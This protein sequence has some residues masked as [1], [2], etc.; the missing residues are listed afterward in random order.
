M[1]EENPSVLSD[2][3][4]IQEVLDSYRE[5]VW[6]FAPHHLKPFQDRLRA[7]PS[8]AMA[9]ALIFAWLH[10]DGL[11]PKIAEDVSHGG[12]DFIC[13]PRGTSPFMVEVTS[14]DDEVVAN[15]SSWPNTSD[16]TGGGTSQLVTAQLKRKVISKA[17]Q[18]ADY[19]RP[20][21]LAITSSHVGAGWLLGT[22]GAHSLLVSDAKITYFPAGPVTQ[23]T[24][25]R[26]SVF[27]GTPIR[28]VRLPPAY[29]ACLPFCLLQSG[30][31]L[32]R[33]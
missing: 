32:S 30:M 31:T 24:D 9:E 5:Y 33:L 17:N 14:L 18:L 10:S 4:T 7:S 13:D 1:V 16:D 20:R 23:T 21:V 19:K 12:M 8:S 2:M 22:M 3:I 15:R 25:L 26:N 6:K 27:F 11:N 28:T 29:R